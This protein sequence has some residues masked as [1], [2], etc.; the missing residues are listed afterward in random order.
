M[1]FSL[2]HYRETDGAYDSETCDTIAACGPNMWFLGCNR[3]NNITSLI[4]HFH[5]DRVCFVSQPV[6]IGLAVCL[7]TASGNHEGKDY[8]LLLSCSTP[9]SR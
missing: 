8:Y 4:P 3:Q 5:L 9:N 1:T 7:Y 6:N 2:T